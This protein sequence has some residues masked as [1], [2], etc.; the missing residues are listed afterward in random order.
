MGTRKYRVKQFG[1][2][3]IVSIN[4]ND[5]LTITKV[6]MTLGASVETLRRWLKAGEF[7]P[8]YIRPLNGTAA[9]WLRIDV[10]EWQKLEL[11]A[12]KLGRKGA[13]MKTLDDVDREEERRFGLLPLDTRGQLR[14]LET[15]RNLIRDDPA[16]LATE[17]PNL[18]EWINEKFTKIAK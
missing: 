5:V 17:H 18:R 10:V 14:R 7:P 4:T 13:H 6:A 11:R 8:S 16:K 12:G 1:A 9:L 15:M 2:T 3:V